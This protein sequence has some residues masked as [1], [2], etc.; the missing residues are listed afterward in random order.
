[1]KSIICIIICILIL[2][3]IPGQG[4]LDDYSIGETWDEIQIVVID[5][6]FD[7][8][9][10]SIPREIY[11]VGD[12]LIFEYGIIEPSVNWYDVTEKSNTTVEQINAALKGTRLAGLGQAYIDAELK[13]QI[14]AIYL[15]AITIHESAWGNSRLARNKNNISGFR[16]YDSNPYHDALYFA[17]KDQCIMRTAQLL[18]DGY[19]SRGLYTIKAVGGRYATDPKWSV[20]VHSIA[21]MIMKRF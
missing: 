3:A 15:V 7:I 2:I 10:S 12:P 1:M 11:I 18:R 14:N 13:Y 6:D 17:T 9:D 5:E 20:K 4:T 16:A 19:I 21:K 8:L